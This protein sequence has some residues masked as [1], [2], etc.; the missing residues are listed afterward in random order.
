MQFLR[1]CLNH[2]FLD[3][4][5]PVDVWTTCL[6]LDHAYPCLHNLVEACDD[7]GEDDGHDDGHYEHLLDGHDDHLLVVNIKYGNI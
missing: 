7:D 1:C 3:A 5:K 2:R 4:S 6:G